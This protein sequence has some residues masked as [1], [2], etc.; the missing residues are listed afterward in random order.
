MR[1]SRKQESTIPQHHVSEISDRC[2]VALQFYRN[3]EFREDNKERR[4]QSDDGLLVVFWQSTKK[5]R[6][7]HYLSKELH[8]ICGV[9]QID[10]KRYGAVWC[11]G[12]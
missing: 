4:K 3:E 9:R 12:E 2:S 5:Q 7:V 1:Y 11:M 10:M 6:K 8:H